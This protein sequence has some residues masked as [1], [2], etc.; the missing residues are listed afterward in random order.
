M[1]Q[2]AYCDFIFGPVVTAT[3]PSPPLVVGSYRCRDCNG[4]STVLSDSLHEEVWDGDSCP[5]CLG[6]H[7]SYVG[8]RRNL[9]SEITG[10]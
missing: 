8:R 3:I 9:A 7:V 5:F 10:S 6:T 4:F 1:H 2:S